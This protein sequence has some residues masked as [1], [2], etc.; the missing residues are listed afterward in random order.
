MQ[1]DQRQEW[2]TM[3]EMQQ[4]LQIGSTKA[5]ELCTTPGGI[6]NVRIGRNIRINKQELLDWLEK[7]KYQID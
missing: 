6:P 3:K 2:L 5:Y 4:I 7:Q 1:V